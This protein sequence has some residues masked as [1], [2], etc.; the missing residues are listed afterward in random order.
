MIDVTKSLADDEG[1]I[2]LNPYLVKYALLIAA[3]YTNGIVMGLTPI[4]TVKKQCSNHGINY[5]E[6]GAVTVSKVYDIFE[7]LRRNC[8]AKFS[9]MGGNAQGKLNDLKLLFYKEIMPMLDM[10][11]QQINLK[12]KEKEN[13]LHNTLGIKTLDNVIEKK[14]SNPEMDLIKSI[15]SGGAVR[16]NYKGAAQA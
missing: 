3:E 10:D 5:N 1:R 7:D 8:Y 2:V 15:I 16:P 11:E 4:E 9:I 12:V 13:K 14:E 6:P